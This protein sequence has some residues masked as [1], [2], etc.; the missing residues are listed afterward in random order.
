MRKF[1]LFYLLLVFST[2]YGQNLSWSE[3]IK[4]QTATLAEFEEYVTMKGWD[5]MSSTTPK[6]GKLSGPGF[7]YVDHKDKLYFSFITYLYDEKGTR[8]IISTHSKNKY[9]EYYNGIKTLNPELISSKSDVE[10]ITKIYKGDFTVYVIRT[11]SFVHQDLTLQSWTVEIRP[12]TDLI[13]ED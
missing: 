12:V 6:E 11:T 7:Q 1:L 2:F 3:L 8:I 13:E 4:L 5:Y 10:G 9:L